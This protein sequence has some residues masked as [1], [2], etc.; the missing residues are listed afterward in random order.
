MK[1]PLIHG[2]F[3]VYETDIKAQLIELRKEQEEI[4]S[5]YAKNIRERTRSKRAKKIKS[6]QENNDSTKE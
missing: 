5:V 2:S 4:R 1:E 6:N 3:K